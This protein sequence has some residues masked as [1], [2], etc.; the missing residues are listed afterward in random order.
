MN[1]SKYK[2]QRKFLLETCAKIIF[3]SDWSKKRFLKDLDL[4]IKNNKICTINQSTQ[5]NYINFKHKKN[6]IT[7]VGKLN[8]NKGYDLFGEAIIKIL[9]KYPDWES[10]VIGDEPR[11][12]IQFNHNRLKI[13]GF[14]D[15]DKVIK[16]LKKTSI[17]VVCSRWEEPFGRTS[18]EASANGC[19]VI[20][21]NR[22]GLPETNKHAIILKTLDSK[23]IFKEV[24]NLIK[25]KKRLSL[26]K[27]LIKV[28]F[29]LMN[30]FQKKLIM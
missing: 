3:N 5:K 16:L 19:A 6:I 12:K 29:L 23:N 2:Y 14:Q 22:G 15:H 26:Q 30:L 11:D 21:S 25:N 17:S 24:D 27:N 20:I 18:L 8:L 13:V 1:G 7:F 28:F 4:P 10:I 9:N